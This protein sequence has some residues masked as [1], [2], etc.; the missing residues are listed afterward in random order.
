MRRG[1][2][3][4]AAARGAYTGKPRPVVIV[5]DDR[6]DSTASVTVCPLT[7]NPVEAPLVRIAVEPT[8]GTGIEKPSQIMVDKV[9]TMPRAN[10]RDRL[11]R[12]ADADL[13]R[14]DRALVVFLG[15]AD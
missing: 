2:I 1:E 13:V 3:Y 9:T 11:G 4:V 12:L 10:V 6:F 15:L 14:L 8:A 5:Q 7:T